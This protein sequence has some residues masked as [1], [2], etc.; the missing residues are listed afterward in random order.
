M[1]SDL[2][3]SPLSLATDPEASVTELAAAGFAVAEL[4]AA[5]EADADAGVVAVCTCDAVLCVC[6]L[7]ATAELGAAA[8]AWEAT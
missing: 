2:G 4:A 6:T 8:C 5:D 3:K 7:V 1:V